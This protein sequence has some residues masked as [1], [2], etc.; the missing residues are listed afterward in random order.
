[1]FQHLSLKIL[2]N[3][4]STVVMGRMGRF[5][6]NLMTWVTPTNGKLIDR[7]VRYCEELLRQH[8]GTG[9]TGA[10]T[11]KMPS[12]DELVSKIFAELEAARPNESIVM[13]VVNSYLK[14]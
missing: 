9:T 1:M 14:P 2:L 12:Y 3:A 13:N 10:A 6:G 7:S 8:S 5:E 4:H 11:F